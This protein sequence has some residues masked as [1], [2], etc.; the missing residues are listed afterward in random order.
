MPRTKSP[1]KHSERIWFRKRGETAKAFKAF[2][3]YRDQGP[4]RSLF[5]VSQLADTQSKTWLAKWSS[6]YDWVIR[7][8]AW[9][10]EKDRIRVESQAD[11]ARAQGRRIAI[12][13]DKMVALADRCLERYESQEEGELEARDVVRLADV[14]AKLG[15]LVRGQPTKRVV[16]DVNARI[17]GVSLR[18]YEE[19]TTEALE[20]LL[21]D[22]KGET[23]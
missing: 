6:K 17:T 14:G 20:K 21:M 1:L 7:A 8:E 13:A 18:N 10:D 22:G 9:D 19:M 2:G 3:L 4:M 5:K 12:V 11:E 15:L 23:E 16:T